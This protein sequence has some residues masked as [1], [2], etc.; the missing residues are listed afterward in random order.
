MNMQDRDAAIA[1]MPAIVAQIVAE[2]PGD[3]T[4]DQPTE[5]CV[6]A[7]RADG[8]PSAICAGASRARP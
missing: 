4:T 8:E 2:L 1:A 6:R 5:Y 7:T 3:W